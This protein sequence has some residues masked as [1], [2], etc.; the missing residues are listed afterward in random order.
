MKQILIIGHQW[1]EPQSTAAGTRILQLLQLLDPMNNTI[2]FA[3]A[4]VSNEY[5][6]KL[7][8]MGITEKQIK[9]N[10][11]SF[12]EY[13]KMLQPDVVIFDR[14]VTEEHYGWRVVQTC[15]N[16]ITIL[17]TEDLHFL[18][19]A[20]RTALAKQINWS[21]TLL[22]T[23]L[24][25]REITSILRCDY[26]LIISEMEMELLQNIFEISEEKLVYIPFLI[27]TSSDIFD[28]ELRTYEDRKHFMMIGNEMHAPNRD[29]VIY[30]KNVIWPLI[31]RQLPQAELH[32]YGSYQSQKTQQFHNP[33]TGFL[34]KGRAEEAIN[35]MSNY[36]LLLAP[37]RFGAGLKGKIFDALQAG[38]PVAMTAIAAEAMFDKSVYGF[39]EEDPEAFVDQAVK[40]YQYENDWYN[41]H[42]TNHNILR[43][44]FEIS[45]F[46][47][48]LL[49]VIKAKKKLATPPTNLSTFK[50]KM[51]VDSSRASF[52]YM[53]RWITLKNQ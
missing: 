18:R 32:V 10:D 3:T 13:I 19:E 27:D 14:F 23:D 17:D 47:P 49:A 6:A 46:K 4:A 12:D 9:L 1:P 45:S 39:V 22:F 7:A 20:R 35:T 42:T 38:T 52:K 26:S 15:P 8:D 44:R 16:A 34:I 25:Q 21:D 33:K 37:L 24:A 50:E 29:A 41:I 53:S 48:Q 2:H 11:D 36:R 5:S 40:L 31:R 28:R 43:E 30:T 51:L